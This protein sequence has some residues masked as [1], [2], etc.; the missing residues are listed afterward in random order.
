MP[1]SSWSKFWWDCKSLPKKL[2]CSP[3]NTLSLWTS[4]QMHWDKTQQVNACTTWIKEKWVS[5]LSRYLSLSR[6]LP[7][8]LSL[9][10]LA[11]F[12]LC[13]SVFMHK[14]SIF[15]SFLARPSTWHGEWR[16]SVASKSFERRRKREVMH[17]ER[18][19]KRKHSE[20]RFFRFF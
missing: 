1:C 4:L 6:A 3:N 5:A 20:K 7:L 11:C 19:S 8:S 12:S 16:N 14:M 18:T 10:N 2:A 9:S 15:I 17:G 13:L